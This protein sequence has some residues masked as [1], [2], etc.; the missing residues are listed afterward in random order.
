MKSDLPRVLSP[1][2]KFKYLL[3]TVI[4]ILI[5]CVVVIFRVK[6][7]CITSPDSIKLWILTLLVIK[8]A[9]LLVVC[10]LNHDI[11]GYEDFKMSIVHFDL[12]FV[13]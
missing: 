1:M 9:I 3:L 8:F 4:D 6:V 12:S 13:W 5:T 10:Q 2:G 7:D 11:L